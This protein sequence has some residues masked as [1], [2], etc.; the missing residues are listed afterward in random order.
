M[1]IGFIGAGLTSA[2]GGRTH[3]ELT[4]A[5]GIWVAAGLGVAAGF[6]YTGTALAATVIG[7]L[8]FS[9]LL[10]LENRLRRSYGTDAE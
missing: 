2:T 8:I 4:T 10:R 7:I 3:A 1:G 9:L 5:T 6:G